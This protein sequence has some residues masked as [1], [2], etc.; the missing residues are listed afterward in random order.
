MY[1][2]KK[3]EGQIHQSYWRVTSLTWAAYGFPIVQSW[4]SSL[5]FMIVI[6]VLVKATHS[7]I[8]GLP[9]WLGCKESSCNARDLGSIPGLGR[10]HGEGNSYPLQYSDLENSMDRRAWQYMGSQRVRHDWVTFTFRALNQYLIIRDRTLYRFHNTFNESKEIISKGLKL[11]MVTM[12]Q[13][14]KNINKEK[15]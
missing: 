8:L 2:G 7:S 13:L 12:S 14:R 3:G 15:L 11:S 1:V 4:M 9:W 10:S 6:L 5:F